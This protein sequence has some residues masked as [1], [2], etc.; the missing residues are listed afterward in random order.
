MAAVNR[1]LISGKG[2]NGPHVGFNYMT[3]RFIDGMKKEDTVGHI[4][5]GITSS[6]TKVKPFS[7]IPGPRGWP[8]VG[9]MP[10]YTSSKLCFVYIFRL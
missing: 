10:F 9:N 3:I 8:I 4:E 5:T 1:R 2:G 7:A 6:Q